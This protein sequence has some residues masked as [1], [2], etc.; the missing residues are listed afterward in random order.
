MK[1]GPTS[2]NWGL[3]ENWLKSEE[4]D[5]I[6]YKR[7]AILV[8]ARNLNRKWKKTL[9]S[10]FSAILLPPFPFSAVKN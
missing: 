10:I 7:N 2:L 9:L 4:L 8:M 1:N 5:R 3:S 6:T